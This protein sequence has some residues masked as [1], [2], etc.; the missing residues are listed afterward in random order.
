[1]SV[2]CHKEFSNLADT[3]KIE[4]ILAVM[5]TAEVIV[6]L[7]RPGN[8]ETMTSAMPEQRSTN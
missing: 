2:N 6:K 7:I 4:A 8:H 1:M 5:N 3:S